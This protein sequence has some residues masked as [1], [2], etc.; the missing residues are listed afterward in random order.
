MNPITLYKDYID[1]VWNKNNPNI[2][3][4]YIDSKFVV[5]LL[6]IGKDVSGINWVKQDLA[7]IYS[8]FTKFRI[9]IKKIISQPNC[10]SAV[11]NLDANFDKDSCH[12]NEIVVYQI[13]N[14]KFVEAWEIGTDWVIKFNSYVK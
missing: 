4:K 8:Q 9:T 12:M 5:H 3:D 14:D 6:G 1:N 13:K 7:R 11:L 2:V 10:I